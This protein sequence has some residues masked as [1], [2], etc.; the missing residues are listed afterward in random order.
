MRSRCRVIDWV[1]RVSKD[2]GPMGAARVSGVGGIRIL[3][4]ARVL[5]L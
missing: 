4:G 2:T 1:A 3:S 5:A